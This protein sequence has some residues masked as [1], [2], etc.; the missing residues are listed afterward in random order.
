[1]TTPTRAALAH[2]LKEELRSTPLDKVAVSRLTDR[3]GV[4]RQTFYYHFADVY[5]LATWVFESEVANHIMEHASYSEWADGYR[6]LL[7]YFQDHFDQVKAVMD[8]LSHRQTEAFFMAQFRLMMQAIVAELQGEL[9]LSAA[10][11]RFVV[12]HYAAT[13]LGHFLRWMSGGGRE[14]PTIL[15]GKIEKVLRGSVRESLERFALPEVRTSTS[16]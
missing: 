1:M 4:T 13:V 5:D 8:S 14:D 9:T 15:V 10:D 6:E 12:D 3:A 11:R 16:R 2:A 7:Q